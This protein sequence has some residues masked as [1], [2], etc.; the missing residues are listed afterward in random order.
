MSKFEFRGSGLGYF[1][2]FVWTSLVS[3]V[4]FGLFFP[5]AYSAQQRW[6]AAN[7]YVGGRQQAFVGSGLGLLGH[8]LLIM[9]LTF[10]TFGLYTPWAY[11]RLK[12]WEVDNTVFADELRGE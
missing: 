3:I 9:V 2:L 7:T 6:I 11:C 1:W 12:R 5:W 8:W 10:I 4:T